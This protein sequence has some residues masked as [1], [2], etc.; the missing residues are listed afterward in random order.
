[1]DDGPHVEESGWDGPVPKVIDY[2]G[3]FAF[4]EEA[5]FALVRDHGVDHLSH[6]RIAAKLGTSISTVR[7]LLSPDADLRVVTLSEV[8]VR[9][10]SGRPRPPVVEGVDGALARLRRLLP[11]SP[12]RIA[13]ELV[14]WRLNL[15]APTHPALPLDPAHLEEGPLHHR[16]A[17]ANLGYVPGHVLA[18]GIAPPTTSIDGDGTLDPVVE[19]RLDHDA[20]VAD[21]VTAVLHDCLSTLRGDELD[22]AAQLVHGLLDGL[23][24]AVCLGRVAPEDAVAILRSQLERLTSGGSSSACP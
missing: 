8:R 14:W 12:A 17:V 9:R 21:E 7:R 6:H 2:A 13:E 4:F 10:R 24:I 15:A 1:V 16:F 18:L 20:G 23:G 11:D 22:L 5:C 3:R 19:D